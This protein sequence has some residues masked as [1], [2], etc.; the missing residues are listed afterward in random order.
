M[1]PQE[2][3]ISEMVDRP[4]VFKDFLYVFRDTDSDY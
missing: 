2:N 3:V 4:L 1:T